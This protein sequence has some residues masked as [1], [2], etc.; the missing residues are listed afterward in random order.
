ME[1]EATVLFFRADRLNGIPV[2]TMRE[3]PFFW[4]GG[5]AE[6]RA[7]FLTLLRVSFRGGDR[8]VLGIEKAN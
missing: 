5:G 3:K 4:G 2:V 7:Y 8:R 1:D 6:N